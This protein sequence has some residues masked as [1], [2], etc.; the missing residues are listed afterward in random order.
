VATRPEALRGISNNLY[1]L[2]KN[3]RSGRGPTSCRVD[4]ANPTYWKW[5]FEAPTVALRRRRGDAPMHGIQALPDS[6]EHV[7]VGQLADDLLIDA[8]TRCVLFCQMHEIGI[9]RFLRRGRQG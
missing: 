3:S 5:F 2:G 4:G 9:R 7:V 8:A 6:R 1:D